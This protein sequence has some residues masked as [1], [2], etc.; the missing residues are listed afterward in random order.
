MP[1]IFVGCVD[2]IPDRGRKVIGHDNG[3]VG[4][5]RLDGRFYA[6]HNECAHRGGPICQ[7]RL[8]RDVEEP[9]AADGTVGAMR[10]K[11]SS[12]NIVCPWHGYEYDLRTGI[13]VANPTLRLREAP[14]EIRNGEIYVLV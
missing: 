10:Y 4:V 12:L 14:I 6:W 3:E 1:A 8:Y 5:F 2:D 7:G 11:E 13:N 9:V